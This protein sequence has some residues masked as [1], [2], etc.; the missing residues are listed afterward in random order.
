M[1][2]GASLQVPDSSPPSLTLPAQEGEQ[3]ETS[4]SER[5]EI[6]HPLMR[7]FDLLPPRGERT[8]PAPG[9]ISGYV[10]VATIE[11][12]RPAGD[13]LGDRSARL[14]DISSRHLR[15]ERLTEPE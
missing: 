3:D 7:D 2:G 15:N 10:G 14:D 13:A 8:A 9:I 5:N 1:A 12:G 4:S 6:T 11:M